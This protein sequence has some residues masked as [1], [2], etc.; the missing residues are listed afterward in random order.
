MG[1]LK[2]GGGQG[3]KE[4]QSQCRD[5]GR[6]VNAL[7]VAL[8]AVLVVIVPAPGSAL[9]MAAVSQATVRSPQSSSRQLSFTAGMHK[10]CCILRGAARSTR[11]QRPQRVFRG[12]KMNTGRNWD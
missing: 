3:E 9:F 6:V 8:I 2:M 1:W 7:K 4:V 10:I 5:A 12:S 11:T